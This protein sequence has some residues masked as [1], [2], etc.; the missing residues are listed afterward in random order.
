MMISAQR[1]RT[2]FTFV[3][4][5]IGVVLFLLLL[6]IVMQSFIWYRHAQ[7]GME[8]LDSLHQLRMA[9]WRIG[10]ELAFGTEI[11]YPE[12]DVSTTF[13]QLAVRNANNEI[14]VF[15]R[16]DKNQLLA[17]NLMKKARKQPHLFP[18][19]T[20]VVA[21]DVRRPSRAYV[22]YEITIRDEKGVDFHLANS[23]L[24][25]NSLK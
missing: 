3:E 20:G 6:G 10:E 23:S 15:F 11:L 5:I 25:K 18:L 21:L 1:T 8:R 4:A 12:T 9:T 2:G 19:A 17:T 7:S 16:N 14:V 22:E 13:H 24:Q